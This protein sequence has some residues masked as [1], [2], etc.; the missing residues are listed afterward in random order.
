MSTFVALNFT[1]INTFGM[2]PTNI[3]KSPENRAFKSSSL[4]PFNTN[5][6]AQVMT[7]N[8]KKDPQIRFIL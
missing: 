7:C 4:V 6:V 5:L 2:L 8:G 1:A 3:G